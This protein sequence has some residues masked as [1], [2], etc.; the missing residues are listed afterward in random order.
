MV[1]MGPLFSFGFC[2][3]FFNP[4]TAWSLLLCDMACTIIYPNCEPT[5]CTT[6]TTTMLTSGCAARRQQPGLRSKC[7]W[8]VSLEHIGNSHGKKKW[9]WLKTVLQDTEER[10]MT[11]T[12]ASPAHQH[13]NN[14]I[15]A[16]WDTKYWWLGK[17][18]SNKIP[19]KAAGASAGI[20]SWGLHQISEQGTGDFLS[21]A[22]RAGVAPEPKSMYDIGIGIR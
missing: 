15:G 6:T 20:R 12:G 17:H 2:F 3:W 18:G 1:L 22:S 21:Q 16:G 7:C 10:G 19:G 5:F 4:T 9:L 14:G 13:A 8:L 11:S